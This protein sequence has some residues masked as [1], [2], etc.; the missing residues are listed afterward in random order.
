MLLAR[1][2]RC[3]EV[4]GIMV[5][6]ASTVH[7][8]SPGSTLEPLRCMG[9]LGRLRRSVSGDFE[10]IL[11]AQVGDHGLHEAGP[12]PV[13]EAVFHVI[14][15]AHQVTG[16]ASRQRWHWTETLQPFAVA[17]DALLIL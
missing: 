7:S 8:A 14:H 16:G 17:Q 2:L 13:A 5:C 11:I 6:P 9:A 15:L 1:G 12:Q 4:G 3:A 10:Q